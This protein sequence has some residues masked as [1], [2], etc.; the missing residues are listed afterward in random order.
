MHSSCF[1]ARVSFFSPS[2]ADVG[3]SGWHTPQPVQVSGLISKM[4]RARQTRA[5]HC[6]FSTWAK[7]SSSK[8]FRDVK[9][10]SVAVC[11][12]SHNDVFL[13]VLAKVLRFSRS[14]RVANPFFIFARISNIRVVPIR[15]GTHF[16]HDT[17][18]VKEKK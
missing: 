6:F 2:I 18:C 8:Y 7:Y 16:P 5:G 15:H 14:W 17:L 4:I 3:Q 9:I 13:T 10:G 1:I 12:I 11:P